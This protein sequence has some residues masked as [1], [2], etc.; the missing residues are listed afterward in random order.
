L[1]EGFFVSVLLVFIVRTPLGDPIKDEERATNDAS[2][3]PVHVD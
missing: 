1:V 3:S 2:S